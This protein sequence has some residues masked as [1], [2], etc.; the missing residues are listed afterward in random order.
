MS[1]RREVLHR[2]VIEFFRAEVDRRYRMEYLKEVSG[3]QENDLLDAVD[4]ETLERAKHFFKEV[5]YP[6]G[7]ERSLR[8]ESVEEVMDILGNRG[9]IMALLPKMPGFLLRHGPALVTAARAGLEVLS[10]FRLSTEIEN[11]AVEHLDELREEEGMEPFY[12]SDGDV[13]PEDLLRR[14]FALVPP[15]KVERMMAHLRKLTRLGM[16]RGTV[17][18]TQEVL[19][20]I[21]SGVDS[22][23]EKEAID[24]ALWVL[25]RLDEEV[26]AHSRPLMEQLLQIAEHVEQHYL[27]ELSAYAP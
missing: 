23:H 22:S 17:A 3:V 26:E 9:R 2:K 13:I 15:R 4:A 19:S 7:E 14:A 25:E 20:E 18:A 8:D 6:V 24:Y 16:Q 11:Q 5:L 10:T 1:D 27:E 12:E 21:R